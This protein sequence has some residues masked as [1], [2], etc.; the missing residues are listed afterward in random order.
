MQKFL[1]LL[2]DACYGIERSYN[3]MRLASA[4]SKRRLRGSSVSD[5]RCRDLWKKRAEDASR[6]L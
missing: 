3:A 6:L 1:F 5:G 4:L 2:N